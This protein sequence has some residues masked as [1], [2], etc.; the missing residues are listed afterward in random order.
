MEAWHSFTL[1]WW[2]CWHSI[3]REMHTQQQRT[4]LISNS[5][6]GASSSNVVDL[7]V[8]YLRQH[9]AAEQWAVQH[10]WVAELMSYWLRSHADKYT[11]YSTEH[12]RKK[13]K[14]KIYGMKL[15]NVLNKH[16]IRLKHY[17][18]LSKWRYIRCWWQPDIRLRSVWCYFVAVEYSATMCRQ[19]L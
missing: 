11:T 3:S 8:G 12:E 17:Y 2:D 4:R 6:P 13:E 1:C 16:F 5:L 9:N 10:A 19:H 18:I 14:T 7:S 15:T